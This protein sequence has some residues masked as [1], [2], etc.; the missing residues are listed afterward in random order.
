MAN[1]LSGLKQLFQGGR[2]RRRPIRKQAAA[3]TRRR[4]MALE[5]LEDRVTPS[6]LSLTAGNL[7]YLATSTETNNLTVSYLERN[8]QV[9]IRRH[10]R[11]D[12]QHHTW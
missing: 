2:G 11:H 9:H 8:P 10:R 12:H 7:K 3:K 1:W 5:R 4:E 6:T